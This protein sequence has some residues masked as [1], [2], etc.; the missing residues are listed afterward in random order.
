MRTAVVILN[1]NTRELLQRFLPGLIAS[2]EGEDAEVIVADSG[3][4]DS[5]MEM[6][7]E[8][9]PQVR[10]IPLGKNYGFTGGYNRA[11]GM[12][13]AEYFV[14][15][16][17]DVEVTGGWLRPLTEWMDTHPQCGACAPKLLSWK[18]RDRFEY[19]G[20]AGGMIDSWGY[21]FC[22]GRILKLTEKDSG[23]YDT[24]ADV[25]WATGA[26]LMVRSSVWKQC[27]GLDD[28]FFAHMEEID[29]C[30]RMQLAGWKVQVVPQ[31]QVFHLGGATLPA[32]S[33]WKLQLNFRNN[34]LMLENNLARTYSIRYKSVHKALRKANRR[35]GGRMLLDMG[36][37]LVYL[38]TFKWDYVKAVYLAHE[39]FRQMRR[40]VS[41]SDLVE[42]RNGY[43]AAEEPAGMYHGAILLQS[44]VRGKH[45]FDYIRSKTT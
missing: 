30:W 27:G 21:T 19:A 12:I 25:L 34:L 31:S 9:F 8:E 38:V 44:F 29:L 17:S 5:S 11:L 41:V 37:A 22:R 1:W 6:M 2:C 39:Q 15:I 43:P 35:I 14:L 45:I 32:T 18:D 20:A 33:P 28:R 16:N 13:E 4:T 3:S 24:P 7:A 36:S 40:I 10:T 23:Q 26:C 42:F